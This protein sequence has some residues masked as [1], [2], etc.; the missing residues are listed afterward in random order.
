MNRLLILAAHPDD[1][2]IGAGALL[3]RIHDSYVAYLTDGAPRDERF[4]AKGFSGDRAAYSRARRAEAESALTL[5]GLD[6]NQISGSDVPDQEAVYEIPL[7]TRWLVDLCRKTD[8]HII[9]VHPYEGGHPDHDAAA[10]V[11]S[12][13]CRVLSRQGERAPE[14]WEMT[15]Y[16]A[17][18]GRFVTG[19]FLAAPTSEGRSLMLTKHERARKKRMFDQFRT[20]RGV[21]AAFGTD[22]EL[23]RRAPT[24]DF[25]KP[26][27]GGRLHYEHLGWP[28]TGQ[29]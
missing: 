17:D 5:A 9:V 8:P 11:A 22:R 23:F 7:L 13:A 26:P 1:E 27:H 15:S 12:A 18:D 6:K 4:I 29:G 20:Q 28:L 19:R 2:T 25:S 14:L 3:G 16:Y 10:L 24:Y 21:L